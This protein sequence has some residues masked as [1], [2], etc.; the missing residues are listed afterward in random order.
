MAEM[1]PFKVVQ[2]I[3]PYKVVINAGLEA[4]LKKGDQFLLYTLGDMIKDPDTGEDLEQVEITKGTGT[5][6]HLQN[7]IA[8][9]ESN[10]E[11]QKPIKIKQ[12][13]GFGGMR[14]FFGDTEETELRREDIP[15]DEPQVGD[16]ARLEDE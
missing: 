2:I 6:S 4:G 15:F 12:V 10:M 9:I 8:T 13:S 7:K 16:L 11:E 1:G 3:S 5:V 14:N